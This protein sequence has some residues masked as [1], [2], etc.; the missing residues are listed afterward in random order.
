MEHVLGLVALAS[1]LIIG[2]GA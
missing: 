2:L 1:G